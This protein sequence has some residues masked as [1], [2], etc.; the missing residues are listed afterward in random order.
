MIST[1][2]LLIENYDRTLSDPIRTAMKL[3]VD[4]MRR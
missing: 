3:F 1:M 2:V 4:F